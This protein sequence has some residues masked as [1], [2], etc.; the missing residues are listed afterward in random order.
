MLLVSELEFPKIRR[1]ASIARGVAYPGIEP[2][3]S[4]VN[5]VRYTIK[6]ISEVAVDMASLNF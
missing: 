2:R 3:F 4:H 6:L 5:D 1:I